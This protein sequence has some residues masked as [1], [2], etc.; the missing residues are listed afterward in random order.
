MSD[1]EVRL[2]RD[3]L[4]KLVWEKPLTRIAE[5]LGVKALDI[6]AECDDLDVPRPAAGYWSKLAHGKAPERPALP[7]RAEGET[8]EAVL[9]KGTA[10]PPEAAA[11]AE[12]EAAA[13]PE[14]DAATHPED[15]DEVPTVTVPPLPQSLHPA[16]AALRKA[17]ERRDRGLASGD[18]ELDVTAATRDRA[19]GILDALARVLS[20]RGHTFR[21]DEKPKHG[22]RHSLQVVVAGETIGIRMTERAKEVAREPGAPGRKY[23]YVPSGRLR[24]VLHAERGLASSTQ[25]A[26]RRGRSLEELLGRLVLAIE[27]TAAAQE[28]RRREEEEERRQREEE[29]ARREYA[30]RRGPYREA[31][32][33]DLLTMAANWSKAETIL[34]F[35]RAVEDAVPESDRTQGFMAWLAWARGFVATFDPLADLDKVAK[36]VE[37]PLQRPGSIGEVPQPLAGPSGASRG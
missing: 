23:D 35:L 36:M 25:W 4:Y 31:L 34:A 22:P 14:D 27:E 37:P 17:L 21:V 6:A 32:G 29:W 8:R 33:Q 12:A 18:A 3:A 10:L 19:L 30:W 20:S 13:P 9:S 28:P 7:V 1:Q 16:V 5:E 15:E 24:I 2:D 26:D 11:P